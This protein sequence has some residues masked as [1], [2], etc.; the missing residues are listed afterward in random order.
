MP[1]DGYV[2]AKVDILAEDW[3]IQEEPVVKLTSSQFWG[4]FKAVAEDVL[5]TPDDKA[6]SDDVVKRMASL[7]GIDP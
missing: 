6:K 4:A 1:K 2:F 5:A 7:L 3:E